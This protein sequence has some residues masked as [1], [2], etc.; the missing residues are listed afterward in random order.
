MYKASNL[1][2]AAD[3]LSHWDEESK[4]ATGVCE[5]NGLSLP[6]WVDWSCF[7]DKVQRDPALAPIQAA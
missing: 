1:N 6:A 5:C 4:Q 2:G 7:H 3:A